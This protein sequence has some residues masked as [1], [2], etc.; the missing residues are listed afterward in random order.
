MMHFKFLF[1]L[2]ALKES[3]IFKVNEVISSVCLYLQE[4]TSR[5]MQIQATSCKGQREESAIHTKRM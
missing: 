4:G 1:Y 5:K 2:T 3:Y